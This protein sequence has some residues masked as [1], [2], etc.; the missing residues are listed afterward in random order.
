[1]Q[2][3]TEVEMAARLS[4]T[5]RTLRNWRSQRLVPFNKVRK[6]ILFDPVKVLAELEKFERGAGRKR[7][8]A[9]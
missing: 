4:V 6:L 7:E 8:A 3:L 1:M 2:L 9:R 5:P